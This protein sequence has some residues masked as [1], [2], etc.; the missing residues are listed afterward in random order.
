MQ[1]SLEFAELEELHEPALSAVEYSLLQ[2]ERS[3]Y[4]VILNT[5]DIALF[6]YFP[7]IDHLEA[8][9][10]FYHLTGSL[11][12]EG[13]QALLSRLDNIQ[14]EE[15]RAL[16]STGQNDERITLILSFQVP[17]I[18]SQ[19]LQLSGQW[20]VFDDSAPAP[21]CFTGM[22][23]DIS[24]KLESERTREQQ[25]K[26]IQS[27]QNKLESLS[28]QLSAGFWNYDSY[29]KEERWDAKMYALFNTTE[30]KNQNPQSIRSRYLTAKQLEKHKELLESRPSV[31]GTSSTEYSIILNDGT[32][33]Y[34]HE[35]VH[36]FV[37]QPSQRIQFL[38]V[39]QDK[40]GEKTAEVQLRSLIKERVRDSEQIVKLLK[41]ATAA[42]DAKKLFFTNVQNEL[43]SPLNSILGFASIL[44][45]GLSGEQQQ[46]AQII[47]KSGNNLAQ[48]IHDLME[49]AAVAADKQVFSPEWFNISELVAELTSCLVL[50]SCTKD[51]TI[52]SIIEERVPETLYG[53]SAHLLQILKNL[54]NNA[55]K[56]TEK[57]DI[58]IIV[59]SPGYI[60]KDG[61]ISWLPVRFEIQ[62]SGVGIAQTLLPNI[63]ENQEKLHSS[64]QNQKPSGIGLS[65]A[66]VLAELMGGEIG[67]T[68]EAQ[69]GSSF[70]L[71]VPFRS[72]PEVDTHSTQDALHENFNMRN[73]LANLK[74]ARLNIMLITNNPNNAKTILSQLDNLGI[75]ALHVNTR[76]QALSICADTPFNAILLDTEQKDTI[77]DFASELRT[78]CSTTRVEQY[79]PEQRMNEGSPLP[80]HVPLI[81]LTS[82]EGECARTLCRNNLLDD[83]IHFPLDNARLA[84]IL[85]RYIYH[86]PATTRT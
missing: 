3:R 8:N 22:L 49:Y 63:F 18:G 77:K 84:K 20:R 42:Q 11:R 41:L 35:Y 70:W 15:I 68:S 30:Q 46:F 64:T 27:L 62:D 73:C 50:E 48:R 37:E 25:D 36:Y 86:I 72:N 54:V 53:D 52:H 21:L 16:L 74:Q 38:G 58:K 5:L 57:G 39:C 17:G 23:Q 75:E 13:I 26:T 44:A 82:E 71:L 43:I 59:N 9:A 55:I 6:E 69:K 28:N 12:G 85:E 2:T 65:V 81:V 1:K 66:R 56:F 60:R 67:V 83:Y 78:I 76:E 79:K 31:S 4:S 7:Q 32:K 10:S 45:E 14:R 80:I 51:I 61:H 47:E 24:S 29:S 34:I 19:Y 33:R 40:T